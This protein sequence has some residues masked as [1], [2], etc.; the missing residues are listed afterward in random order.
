MDKICRASN[1]VAEDE[2]G[3]ELFDVVGGMLSFLIDDLKKK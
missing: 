3:M 2:L 1:A